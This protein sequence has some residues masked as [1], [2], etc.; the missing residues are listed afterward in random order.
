[1]SS[2]VRPASFDNNKLALFMMELRRLKAIALTKKQWKFHNIAMRRI[3]QGNLKKAWLPPSSSE[4]YKIVEFE[5]KN[6]TGDY[7]MIITAPVLTDW[8]IDRDYSTHVDRA[9]TNMK[10]L[11]KKNFSEDDYEYIKNILGSAYNDYEEL[12][13]KKDWQMPG[14]GE[15]QKE[16]CGII[17]LCTVR[18]QKNLSFEE[19]IA[20]LEI[21]K[22]NEKDKALEKIKEKARIKKLVADHGDKPGMEIYHDMIKNN[23][24]EIQELMNYVKRLDVRIK[25]N[26][27]RIEE[28]DEKSGDELGNRILVT[29]GSLIDQISTFNGF[30]ENLS[31]SNYIKMDDTHY[32]SY[33]PGTIDFEWKQMCI[34]AGY[35]PNIEIPKQNEEYGDNMKII[36]VRGNPV[37]QVIEEGGIDYT[38][39]STT[40]TVPL[41]GQ[42]ACNFIPHEA[43]VYNKSPEQHS[44]ELEAAE[45]REKEDE[46]RKKNLSRKPIPSEKT[47]KCKASP[48][49]EIPKDSI[50]AEK[51]ECWEP[52]T[53]FEKY[54]NECDN[55]NI[56]KTRVWSEIVKILNGME[57]THKDNMNGR[58]G[59]GFA[60]YLYTKGKYD[61]TDIDYKIYPTTTESEEERNLKMI[62]IKEQVEKYINNNKQNLLDSING[63][64]K[65][66]TEV[67]TKWSIGRVTPE[68][69]AAAQKGR[70]GVFKI[71]LVG[72]GYGSDGAFY[73]NTRT[74]YCDIGFWSEDD[75]VVDAVGGKNIVDGIVPGVDEGFY[76][77]FK[78]RV[79]NKDFIIAEKKMFLEKFKED[80][81]IQHKIPSWE[82]QIKLLEGLGKKEGGRK[83]RTRKRIKK[84]KKRR[85]K[86]KKKRTKKKR[87]KRRKKTRRR[88]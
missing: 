41:L 23:D 71:T 37:Y 63:D 58:Y 15:Y 51:K 28:G 16:G 21:R 38:F 27:K 19:E 64:K 22:E 73:G 12:F 18:F 54:L 65:T 3:A 70:E 82:N 24:K 69:E 75:F 86:K 68:E 9:K 31:E 4:I 44:L 14:V 77:E 7:Q 25:F 84:Y 36:T 48:K 47:K 43:Y 56:Y 72:P 11:Y 59:G 35:W 49:E 1:M 20:E 80:P 55:N 46:H 42:P 32:V 2:I 13:Q 83:K 85:T 66:F 17:S 40:I 34:L 50:V 45:D 26:K 52:K 79:I 29:P 10:L 60:T 33:F 5:K 76:S 81:S 67:L 8:F 87:R 88:K 57:A 61:T 53:K 6:D 30:R 74:A 78:M 62:E 39:Y